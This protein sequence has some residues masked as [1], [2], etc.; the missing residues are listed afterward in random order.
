[1]YVLCTYY[2]ICSTLASVCIICWPCFALHCPSH[3]CYISLAI[4]FCDVQSAVCGYIRKCVVP[5]DSVDVPVVAFICV[6]LCMCLSFAY[7]W[8]SRQNIWIA[9]SVYWLSYFLYSLRI[10]H[11]RTITITY[12]F[13]SY[14]EP[15]FNWPITRSTNRTGWPDFQS[16]D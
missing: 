12:T 9:P 10:E 6:Y 5:S 8:S 13:F 15:C 1:M 16:I 11:F 3:R 4:L 2:I 14:L 7:L